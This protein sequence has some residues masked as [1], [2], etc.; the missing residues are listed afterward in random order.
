MP[1]G[2][3]DRAVPSGIGFEIVLGVAALATL[4]A[5]IRSW[6]SLWDDE[7]TAHDR[8][9]AMRIAVFLLPPVVVLLHELGHAVAT[10]AVGAE[11]VD[12]EYGLF[13]GSVTSA[14]VITADQGWFIAAAGNLVSIAVGLALL[15]AGYGAKRLRRSVRYVL[16]LSGLVELLVALVVYPL[17]SL[18]TSF[19]DWVAIFDFE[20]T[21]VLAGT[22]LVVHVGLLVAVWR[23]WH[24]SLR[25]TLFGVAYDEERRLDALSRSI[26]EAPGDVSRR[27]ALAEVFAQHG[28]LGQAAAALDRA[29]PACGMSARLHLAR[30]RLALHRGRWNDAVVAARAGLAAT[31]T[32]DELRQRLWANEGLALAQMERPANALEAFEHVGEPVIEDLRVKYGRGVARLGAGDRAGGEADLATVVDRLPEGDLLRE[33]AETRLQGQAPPTAPMAGV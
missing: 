26:R 29:V 28:D 19:G 24:S 20:A 23:W 5:M 12:F 33:W 21:P 16:V 7:V 9:L 18:T 13:Q 2:F 17:F 25:T 31:D 15:G 22:A 3:Y 14:G 1:G 27:V 4:V 30:A 32:S 10:W 6:R 11:V 8:M